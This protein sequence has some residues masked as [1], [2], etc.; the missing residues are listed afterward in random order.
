[1]LS[2]NILLVCCLSLPCPPIQ[3]YNQGG[4]GHRLVAV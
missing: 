4:L 1:M 3:S 2:G